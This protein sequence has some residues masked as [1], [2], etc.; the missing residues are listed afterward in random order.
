MI[1]RKKL[2]RR[3]YLPLWPWRRIRKIV[4]FGFFGLA[5]C[6]SLYIFVTRY[7]RIRNIKVIG[8]NISIKIDTFSLPSNLIVFPAH[9][10]EAQLKSE[11]PLLSD[12]S[13]T[14]EFPD[15]LVI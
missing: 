2:F 8:G 13:V 1:R 15:T 12:I 3:R 4:L 7:F 11:N 6:A 5:V 10:L 9:K 14:K